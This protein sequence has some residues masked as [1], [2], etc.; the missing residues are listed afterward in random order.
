MVL[1]WPATGVAIAALLRWGRRLWP[2]VLIG[3]L[4]EGMLSGEAAVLVG[5]GAIG[6]V[7][8]A[9]V[10]AW[11]LRRIGFDRA[12]GSV[13]D[14]M[15]FVLLGAVGATFVGA[16]ID[17][18]GLLL[19]E[20]PPGEAVYVLLSTWLACILGTLL[21][22]PPILVAPVPVAG[23]RARRILEYVGAVLVTVT[24]SALAMGYL[25]N[26]GSYVALLYLPVLALVW[27]SVRFG[28]G[29]ALPLLLFVNALALAATVN[30]EG[31]FSG[32]TPAYDLFLLWTFM[33]TT[34]L[35]VLVTAAL[36]SERQRASRQLERAGAFTDRVLDSLPGV[37]YLFDEQ[38]GLVRWNQRFEEVTG[39]GPEAMRGEKPVS[40]VAAEDQ[41]GVTAA[42]AEVYER[43]QSLIEARLRHTDG[44][45]RPYL[46]TGQRVDDAEGRFLIGV[47]VDVS[48]RVAVES[49][50]RQQSE[51]LQRIIDNIPIMLCFIDANRRLRLINRE[52]ERVLGWS[53]AE[54]GDLGVFDKMYP[55]S[56]ERRRVL[57]HLTSASTEW[58]EY[59]TKVRDGS[60]IDTVWTTVTL[61]DGTIL[62]IGQD[63]TE[64]KRTR[65]ELHQMQKLESIGR[66][67][68]GIAHDFN[69]LLV[70]I[71][72]Y[73]ESS[74]AALPEGSRIRSDLETVQVAAT[75]AAELTQQILAFSRQQQLEIQVVDLNDIVI[76]IQAM[77]GRLVGED[78]R[79][80]FHLAPDLQPVRADANQIGQVLMNLVVNGRDAMPD[81]GDLWIETAN[82]DLTE[83]F[84]AEHFEAH[85]P[86]GPHVTLAV[87]DGGVGMDEATRRLAFEPF[88]T[89][90]DT[91]R[92]TGLG[93]STVFGIVKQHD[94]YIAVESQ[95]G[96]GAV[97]T[98]YLPVCSQAAAETRSAQ[99]RPESEDMGGGETVLVVEDD[100]LVRELVCRVLSGAG[101]RVLEGRTPGEAVAIA[102][103]E[104]GAIDLL[105]SDVVMPEMHGREV[106]LRVSELHPETQV[107]YM[108]GYAP[109]MQAE[110]VGE[111]DMPALLNKPFTID[112]LLQRVRSALGPSGG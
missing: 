46:F 39:R 40:F 50:M 112:N 32:S 1:V 36:V 41:A 23:D 27:S 102:E 103:A 77:I 26:V 15:T 83:E 31:P 61:S 45:A 21:I 44:S 68:A 47:G 81:G 95:P 62:G 18:T 16:L 10:G 72:G 98:V 92:G 106:Y 88:F 74:I 25:V 34:A 97:F 100:A 6:A 76:N 60:V 108:S 94:G 89:S 42:V 28:L 54:A 30:G 70:P 2:G 20:V 7:A 12:L 93:L 9:W 101:Y 111:V 73:V 75:Q 80:Q 105:L 69:N 78:V 33:A 43:G 64:G 99:R 29:G 48:E 55:D 19:A 49:S 24:V 8:E 86:A 66:L 57:Q 56:G 52:F 109:D 38:R 91:G 35:S 63:I 67:S 3:A 37:F 4:A 5:A 110:R 14:V 59:R 107:L 85:H 79:L 96:A 51:V 90:K 11:A 71:L 13:R 17:G 87:R 82:V 53:L 58:R 65:E 104:T 22:A 84:V